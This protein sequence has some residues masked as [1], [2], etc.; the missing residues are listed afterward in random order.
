MN[1]RSIIRDIISESF[2]P[3]GRYL[4]HS[5][6]PINR[7]SIA[8]QG[9]RPERGDQWLSDTNIDGK[10]IFATDSEDRKDHFNSTYDDDFWRIDTQA[11]P[12]VEWTPDPNF[13]WGKYKH[14]YT[15][16]AIPP[17]ALELVHKGTGADMEGSDDQPVN[18]WH[19]PKN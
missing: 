7:D 10:A 1:I 5:S 17:H 4:F 8:S 19:Y 11:C 13:E 12:E 3:A 16:H 14:V 6:N 18:S 2:I 15:R 9:L